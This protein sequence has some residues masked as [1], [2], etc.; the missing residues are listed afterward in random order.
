MKTS[1][2]TIGDVREAVGI[3]KRSDGFDIVVYCVTGEPN[4]DQRLKT[5]KSGVRVKSS[6]P[7]I[8]PEG[9]AL[10]TSTGIT[11]E[12]SRTY[13]DDG[14]ES[15]LG[16]IDS[17]TPEMPTVSAVYDAGE[18]YHGYIGRSNGTSVNVWP[19]ASRPGHLTLLTTHR[20]H[21]ERIV[22]NR[23][24]PLV[25]RIPN[26][27]DPN[28]LAEYLFDLFDYTV[29]TAVGMKHPSDDKWVYAT[30]NPKGRPRKNWD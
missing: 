3:G 14:L 9:N 19:V 2:E 26:F 6:Y 29:C 21:V 22:P 28:E 20:E 13:G 7:V 10:I 15:A 25:K 23:E 16:K 17:G 8:H 4:K 27:R 24:E 5:Y 18:R 11:D 1:S 12:L 30:R